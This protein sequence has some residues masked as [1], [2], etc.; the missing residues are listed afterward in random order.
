MGMEPESIFPTIPNEIPEMENM[1]HIPRKKTLATEK[2]VPIHRKKSLE[3]EKMVPIHHK[4]S[5]MTEEMAPIH[6]FS[7]NPAKKIP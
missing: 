7:I 1:V 4:E 3:T 2:V 5:L 6:R